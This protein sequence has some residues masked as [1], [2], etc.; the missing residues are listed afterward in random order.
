MVIQENLDGLT[1]YEKLQEVF[2]DKESLDKT[3]MSLQLRCQVFEPMT[4]YFKILREESQGSW[5]DPSKLPWEE[6]MPKS[7]SARKKGPYYFTSENKSNG[8]YKELLKKVLESGSYYIVLE[9]YTYWFMPG[10]LA[11]RKATE[12]AILTK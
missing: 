5:F 12:R 2:P 10:G 4:G 8:T 7:A 9:G 3:L 11:R 1:R 6:R